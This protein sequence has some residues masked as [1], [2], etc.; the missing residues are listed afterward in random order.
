MGKDLKTLIR[1]KNEA[2][3][4]LVQENINLCNDL[5]RMCDLVEQQSDMIDLQTEEIKMLRSVRYVVP[6]PSL[7]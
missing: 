3:H 4:L 2:Y 1:E 6:Q 5:E 7:N